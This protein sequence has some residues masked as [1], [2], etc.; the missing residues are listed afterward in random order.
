MPRPRYFLGRMHNWRLY[1]PRYHVGPRSISQCHLANKSVVQ[2]LGILEDV[3]VQANELIFPA[4][5]YVLDMEDEAST[6]VS[7]LILG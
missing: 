3:L 7:M 5:F 2:S 6:K 4:D 1:L